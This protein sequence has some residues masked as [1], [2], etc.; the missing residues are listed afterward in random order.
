MKIGSI[1]ICAA[2][3][4]GAWFAGLSHAAD[5]VKIPD[6]A[7]AFAFGSAVLPENWRLQILQTSAN[8]C[9]QNRADPINACD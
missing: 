5:N 7:Q 1:V 6:P 2:M 9:G 8:E 4:I 3:S